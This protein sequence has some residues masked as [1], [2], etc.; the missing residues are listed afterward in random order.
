[1]SPALPSHPTQD[2]FLAPQ[3]TEGKSKSP[4]EPLPAVFL[5]ERVPGTSQ[6]ETESLLLLAEAFR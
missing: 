1:M 3:E 4:T 2:I 6:H 5:P